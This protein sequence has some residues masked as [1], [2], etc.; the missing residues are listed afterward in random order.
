MQPGDWFYLPQRGSLSALYLP[1]DQHLPAEAA[2]R[3]IGFSFPN[4]ASLGTAYQ[5]I[6]VKPAFNCWALVAT[7]TLLGAQGFQVQI[8][9]LSPGGQRQLFN[10]N[11]SSLTVAGSAANPMFL[12]ETE[13][14]LNGDSIRV[15]VKNLSTVAQDTIWLALWGGDVS[16]SQ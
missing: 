11:L 6:Q 10:T 14:F 15:Q 3:A 9:H 1:E 16:V 7:D 4:V 13:L 5:T 2:L 8:W 12:R